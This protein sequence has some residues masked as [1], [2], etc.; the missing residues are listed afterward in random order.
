MLENMENNRTEFYVNIRSEYYKTC[1]NTKCLTREN[2][3]VQK[4][5]TLTTTGSENEFFRT[6]DIFCPVK[7]TSNK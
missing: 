5:R 1:T 3:K 6:F 7:D 4:T 2:N